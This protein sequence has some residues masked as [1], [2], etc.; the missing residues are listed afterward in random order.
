MKAAYGPSC[1]RSVLLDGAKQA[2]PGLDEQVGTEHH[3]PGEQVSHGVQGGSHQQRLPGDGV[4]GEHGGGEPVEH[5]AP[6]LGPA[7]RQ[8]VHHGR[9]GEDG[10]PAAH[11]KL[12]VELEPARHPDHGAHGAEPHHGLH[13]PC[14][15]LGGGG[16]QGR[17]RAATARRLTSLMTRLPMLARM[18]SCS[19]LQAA[20]SAPSTSTSRWRKKVPCWVQPSAPA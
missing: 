14:P 2:G 12:H 7:R 17:V 3:L 20:P 13:Q 19:R 8:P 15:G 1:G 4:R 16:G 18:S 9:G 6:V 11:H 5:E 10:G